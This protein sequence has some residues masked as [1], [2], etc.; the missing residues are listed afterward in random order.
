MIDATHWEKL[1]AADPREVA[2]RSL[3]R[4]DEER[5][6]FRLRILADDLAVSPGKRTIE[7]LDPLRHGGKPPGFNHCLVSVVYLLSARDVPLAGEWLH[8]RTLPYGE[9]FFRGPH[10]LPTARIVKAF[11]GQPR[12][13][14]EAAKRLDG[15]PW[16][17]ARNA[18]VLPALPRVPALV[19]FW[20]RD[21]EFEARASL[22]FDR[23]VG[24]HLAVDGILA[25]AGIVA[26]ELEKAGD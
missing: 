26:G 11:G 18:F 16:P 19:Q 6:E 24:A 12:R 23:S 9:F 7:W 15:T 4:Y 2:R 1:R 3:A 13:F 25:V 21:E 17:Q 5:G 8:P 10:D 20:E 22:L 14:A